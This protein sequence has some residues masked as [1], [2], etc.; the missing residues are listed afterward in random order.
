MSQ[1]W[2]KTLEPLLKLYHNRK[3]PLDYKNRYQLLVMVI[4]SAQATDELINKVSKDFFAAYPTLSDLARA[5]PEDVHQ[6]LKSVRSF[7]KKTTWLLQIAAMIGEDDKIPVSLD[8]LIQYPGL[9]RK[10]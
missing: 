5:N 2:N 6:L 4:L 3:H 10:S 7:G 9:G 8:A 1:D